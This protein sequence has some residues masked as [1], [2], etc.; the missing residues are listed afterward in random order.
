MREELDEAGEW[1]WDKE[2]GELYV[3]FNATSGTPPPSDGS[4][5]AI[6]DG[7]WALINVAA[8]QEAPARD[9]SF[10][11]IGLRDTAHVFFQP[12]SIPSGGDWALARL[13]ALVL[14]GSEG[15]TV[16]GCLFERVDGTALLISGYNRGARVTRNAFKWI[17]DSAIVAWGKTKG[18]PTGQDGWDAT[19]GNQPRYTFV[20]N[21]IA[22]EVGI[23]EKQSSLYMQAKASDSFLHGNVGFNGPR[24][25]INFN[26][27]A[28]SALLPRQ[29]EQYLTLSSPCAF[30]T[31][32]N[33]PSLL[34]RFRRQF[35]A[36]QESGVQCVP[37]ERR[38]RP[39]FVRSGSPPRAPLLGLPPPFFFCPGF[40]PS[41]LLVHLFYTFP[42]HSTT[43][44]HP[45][46]SQLVGQAALCHIQR[47][48]FHGVLYRLQPPHAE[49]PHLQL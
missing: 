24:A 31:H 23:W 22:S 48:C 9:L 30:P 41:P 40:P 36:A 37:R 15:A 1:F 11:G 10:L 35:H 45:L 12:H 29:C 6:E 21:N 46:R 8:T 32:T 19:D 14:E 3:F 42:T 25:G 38:P 17:G 39:L 16:D 18:D 2:T 5:V 13:G 26:D 4:I 49:L 43:P 47:D 7:A 34:N 28:L 27:G 33:A 20:E 44:P